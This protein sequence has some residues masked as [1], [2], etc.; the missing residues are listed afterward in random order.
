ML[1]NLTFINISERAY[2]YIRQFTIKS[3][4]D[5][6]IELITNSIDAYKKSDKTKYEIVIE[7][8]NE[9]KIVKVRDHA[10][11]M[12]GQKMKDNL[13]QV[14]NYTA[15]SSSRG[16]FSRGAKD[17]SAIGN[18]HFFS[19]KDNK[20]SYCLINSDA[21]GDI[22]IIDEDVT[23]EIRDRYKMPENG[24]EVIIELLPNFY[25]TDMNHL[26]Y[27]LTNVAVLREIMNNNNNIIKFIGYDANNKVCHYEELRYNYP[28]ATTILDI[29][30]HVPEYPEIKARFVIKKCETPIRQPKKENELEF[31]FLMMDD[32]T[33]YEVNTIDDRFRWTPYINYLYGYIYCNSIKEYLLDFDKNGQT[34]KNPY[35]IIDPSRLSGL[36]K[37]HPLIKNILSIP[38]TRLDFILRELNGLMSSKSIAITDLNDLLNELEDMG[39]NILKETDVKI[40]YTPSYDDKLVKAIESDRGKFVSAEISYP[41]MDQHIEENTLDRYVL[42]KISEEIPESNWNN[43]FAL[44][45]EDNLIELQ[46]YD[47]KNEPIE[48]LK[49]LN[50][51]GNTNITK[52]PYLYSINPNTKALV[53]LYIFQRGS[54][55]DDSLHK[56]I[57]INKKLINI[58]FINDL[59]L[60]QRYIIDNTN[61]ITIK[62]NLNNPLIKKYLT[63]T[64]DIDTIEDFISISNFESIN[65]LI[66]MKD[67]MVDILS[68]L[69][70][71]ND[72][73]NN[74]LVLDSQNNYINAQK[75]LDYK[76]NVIAKIE[77]M[78]EEIFKKYIN[79]SLEKKKNNVETAINQAYI[80]IQSILTEE[81]KKKYADNIS[82]IRQSLGFTI[83]DNIEK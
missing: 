2:K 12:S 81:Q 73:L 43:Y 31:G 82:S 67:L 69:I 26:S 65:S 51:T 50:N 13:L 80:A 20:Y 47:T 22:P 9:G 83:N 27:S 32:T 24:M 45:D 41:I 64:R 75:V 28:E 38:S 8:M 17:I 7:I 61:S 35:P 1:S 21:Y 46:G 29:E 14:G 57:T 44:D 5:A 77:L 19:I 34:D 66:F 6:L 60:A 68:H 56:N 70:V 18:I 33:V 72:I 76:N 40:N 74:N 36:N 58:V 71:N 25:C 42:N 78:I 63:N 52:N 62:L 3:L 48:A 53:K 30:Y 15:D 49:L 23:D 39:L 11:G 16:F 59:N 54:I 79:S 4:D 37:S 10:I 55:G